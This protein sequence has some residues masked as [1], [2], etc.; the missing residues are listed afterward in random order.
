MGDRSSDLPN[1]KPQDVTVVH[2]ALPRANSLDE[3]SPLLPH[4][5]EFIPHISL[6]QMARFKDYRP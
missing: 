2:S 1:W 4:F 5:P 3:Q 6:G